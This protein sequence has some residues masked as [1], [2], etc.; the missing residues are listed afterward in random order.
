MEVRTILVEP[1]NEENIGAVAR[2]T[3][4]FG[5]SDLC[6]VRPPDIGKKAYSVASHAYEL[7]STCT[8]VNSVEAATAGSALVA[9]TTSK[10]GFSAHRHMRMPFFS[11]HDL[12]EKVKGKD[13]TLS[14]LF[15]REDTGLLNEEIMQCDLVVSIPTSPV[16]PV[17]NLSHAVAVL[18][19][20]LRDAESDSGAR[21]LACVEDKERLFVHLR[22]FLDEIQYRE[23]KREKTMLMLRRI[24]GRAE[25]TPREVRT[26][27]GILSK[28]ERKIERE[29]DAP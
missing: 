1:K 13:G 2:A 12:R 29:E 11:P 21:L 27:H 20:E 9:G 14:L 4:N 10:L 22:T 15:G 18:L 24:L 6:L 16:Y 5:F 8:I 3:K 17:M 7:L 19:Y 25:L 28:A 26:L 23:H